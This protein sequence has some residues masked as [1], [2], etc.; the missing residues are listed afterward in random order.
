VSAPPDGRGLM[1][2]TGNANDEA[3]DGGIRPPMVSVVI[4]AWNCA[5]YL[6]RALDSVLA[7]Q[8]P[9]DRLEVVVVDDGS[10]DASPRIVADYA[11][12]DP[13]VRLLQ[14]PNAG[15]AAAR[16]RG[17]AA[18]RGELIAFLDADDAWAPGKLAAQAALFAADPSLGLV[19]CGVRFV[20]ADGE[21]VTGWVRQTRIAR[22]D[23]LL[24][25]VCD[26]F[27]ITS[28]V[29][30]PRRVLDEVG[31]FDTSLRVGE[32]N[33]LFL[34]VLAR[35]RADCVDAPMLDRTIRADSLSREDFDLDARNDLKILDDFLAMHP[36]FAR[37]HRRRI[38]ERYAS[39]LYDYGYRL[40]DV[41]QARRARR[42]LLDSLRHR[43][44]LAAGKALLRC[45]LPTAAV[46]LLRPSMQ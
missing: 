1:A 11:A 22:G 39:Y 23:I 14:Q 17:I 34:R 4:P 19:H 43:P 21:E 32:D 35:Y 40:M 41:G 45:S 5:R 10:T 28:A 6:R 8:Y 9:H 26:F 12:R 31:R 27:L 29:M 38:A 13:R 33:E 20:D 42:V 2:A 36:E 3:V 16:N 24:D 30:L 25:F 46:R 7:Q 15:P 37:R 44:T 18:A